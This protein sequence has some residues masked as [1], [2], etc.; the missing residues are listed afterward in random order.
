MSM[1]DFVQTLT[2]EQKAALIKA[3]GGNT[4]EEPISEVV[5]GPQEEQ[6]PPPDMNQKFNEFVMNKE[7]ELEKS[8]KRPVRAK[9]NA[10][11]DT[12]EDRHIETPETSRTPRNRQPPK[13]K[14]VICS[15]CSS[16]EMVNESILCGEFYRCS[17]CVGN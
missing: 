14:R 15:K 11:V 4:E 7:K 10:W 6:A 16:M 13:M 9:E 2:E 1:D 17:R 5:D 12:G 8:S 3:L